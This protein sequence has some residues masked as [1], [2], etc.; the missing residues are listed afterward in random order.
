M[1]YQA[2]LYQLW[3]CRLLRLRLSNSGHV[4][5]SCRQKQ[6][7][8]CQGRQV[9]HI[10]CA[11]RSGELQAETR[12]DGEGYLSICLQQMKCRSYGL[13][14]GLRLGA[15]PAKCELQAVWATQS[16]CVQQMH[17]CCSSS[18]D[19]SSAALYTR[20]PSADSLDEQYQAACCR[21]TSVDG[22]CRWLWQGHPSSGMSMAGLQSLATAPGSPAAVAEVRELLTQAHPCCR[23]PRSHLTS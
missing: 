15:S 13:A 16:Q 1:G 4:S 7:R 22:G 17:M 3:G 14:G 20:L 12:G 21:T 5:A 18:A 6:G 2:T 9:Q 11:D 8:R 23:C 10:M 19:Y